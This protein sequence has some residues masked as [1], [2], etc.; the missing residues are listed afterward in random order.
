MEGTRGWRQNSSEIVLS[1]EF[2]VPPVK[3][4]QRTKSVSEQPLGA[5]GALPPL[6]VPIRVVRVQAWHAPLAW[7]FTRLFT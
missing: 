4:A 6:W 3:R 1:T 7:A 5:S 2:A